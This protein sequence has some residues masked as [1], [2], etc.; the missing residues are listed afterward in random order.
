MGLIFVVQNI[1]PVPATEVQITCVIDPDT[2]QH[3]VTCDICSQVIKL[4][5]R[6]SIHPISQHRNSMN[7]R[8]MPV[9]LVWVT[10]TSKQSTWL[11]V[12]N[13]DSSNSES[14]CASSL[15]LQVCLKKYSWAFT[16]I[17]LIEQD[18][19]ITMCMGQ[20]QQHQVWQQHCTINL[21]EGV[22]QEWYMAIYGV[23][24]I[25]SVLSMLTGTG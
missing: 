5:I 24:L 21:C 2:K 9:V 25:L 18:T 23:P 6:G 8:K 10:M 16:V 14:L 19:L 4:G 13:L 1:S 15:S 12:L 3:L 11:C 22:E 20:H 7:C 17:L